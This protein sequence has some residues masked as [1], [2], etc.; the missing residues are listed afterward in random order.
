MT[1]PSKITI[2]AVDDNESSLEFVSSALHLEGV[3]VIACSDPEAAFETIQE[4]HPE[5]VL[6]DLVMPKLGGMDLLEK[7]SEFDPSIAVVLMTAHYSTESAMEAIRKGACD[8]LDKPIQVA[9]LRERIGQ[10]VE[11][12][13]QQKRAKELEH[14]MLESCRFEGIVGR[15]PLM[16]DVFSRI[17]RIGPHFR[18]A[19]ITGET[20]TGKDLVAR[21]IHR[22][23]PAATGRF[24]PVNCSA[25]VETLL[26]SEMFGHVR[27]S[28]T[29]AIQDK[30][31]LFEHAHGG[32]LFLDEIGDM[33]PGLQA[34]VLRALQNQEIQRVGALN[35]K[36]VDIRVVA[37][38]HYNFY[39][40]AMVEIQVPPLRD[41]KED[42]PLLIEHLLR[43]F[44]REFDKEIRGITQR[45]ALVLARHDW[46]GNVRE[47]ENVIGH[48]CMMATGEMAGVQ[49]LPG[50]LLRPSDAATTHAAAS[51]PLSLEDQERS[52]VVD[53]LSRSKG[54]QS[55]A[56]RQLGIG[57]DALRYKMKKFNL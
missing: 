27:G 14:E 53:A 6:T 19:L 42:L 11:D 10:L 20:G 15:S 26:E 29:G 7:I 22:L 30:V 17:R 12:A 8:Y 3:E 52:L 24:V 32:V 47:L 44:S 37:A 28:F 23:S 35:S 2:V 31:G 39:R 34:K 40:L 43:R 36:K 1:P 55:E 41:R 13:R 49:D 48:A 4:R 46:P 25:V 50:Y 18:T 9:V 56:A 16:W 5:I 21:A 57:R 38:T 33:A 51:G 54:N 45:A